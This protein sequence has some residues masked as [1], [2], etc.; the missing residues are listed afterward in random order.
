MSCQPFW[1]RPWMRHFD[2]SCQLCWFELIFKKN[3]SK[4]F[5]QH[6]CFGEG[7]NYPNFC[8]EHCPH[9]S[10]LKLVKSRLGKGRTY[11]IRFAKGKYI[12]YKTKK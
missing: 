3:T 8:Q 1:Q 10:V 4:Y 11:F 12:C 9:V 7:G 6:L 2:K 5:S